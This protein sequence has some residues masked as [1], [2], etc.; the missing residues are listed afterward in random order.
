MLSITAN[1]SV[2]LAGARRADDR[3]IL[4]RES[5]PGSI[6]I[7]TWQVKA[8]RRAFDR[9]RLNNLTLGLDRYARRN[10][11][12]L[13]VAIMRLR[14]VRR[15]TAQFFGAYDAVL[16]PTVA[17]ETPRLG[18]LDPTADSQQ[19]IDRRGNW[20][21]FTPLHNVTGEPAISLPLA[22]SAS[23]MPVGMML[24]ADVGRE[25]WLLELAF[26]LEEARPWTRIQ[27]RPR[28]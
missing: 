6:D 27:S 12:R 22:E 14:T 1:T 26:E 16:T 2:R 18:H 28:N 25:A 8:I 10:M 24:S 5:I 3:Q 19:I 23:G 9:S 17:D 20:G 13:P 15:R 21:A 4:L 11:H 7:W